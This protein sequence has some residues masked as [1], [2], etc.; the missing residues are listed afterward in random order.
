MSH[1]VTVIIGIY[2][3]DDWETFR[4]VTRSFDRIQKSYRGLP[5]QIVYIPS[6]KIQTVT[7]EE[8]SRF[9]HRS[10]LSFVRVEVL[11]LGFH[12]QSVVSPKNSCKI[13]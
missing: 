5:C 12:V 7:D 10:V 1:F 3:T 2:R 11:K 6:D 9:A 8:G 13:S 4:A